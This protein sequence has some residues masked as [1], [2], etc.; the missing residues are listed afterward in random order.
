MLTEG[1]NNFSAGEY[2]GNLRAEAIADRVRDEG[3]SLS[4]AML[5]QFRKENRDR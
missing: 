1:E 3:G 4:D 2:T 5:Q